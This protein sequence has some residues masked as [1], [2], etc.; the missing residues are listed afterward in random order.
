MMSIELV[1]CDDWEGGGIYRRRHINRY[2]KVYDGD[3]V[4]IEIDLC[5]NVSAKCSIEYLNLVQQYAWKGKRTR[6]NVYVKT[7][8]RRDG[9]VVTLSFSRLVVGDTKG[10]V[11]YLNSDTLDNRRK[12]LS[13]RKQ[14]PNTTLPLLLE[15]LLLIRRGFEKR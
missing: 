8:I 9:K 6:N 2:R 12:N 1:F 7:C 5:N 3:E 4:Y 15:Y 10:N 11:T 14:K 13:I